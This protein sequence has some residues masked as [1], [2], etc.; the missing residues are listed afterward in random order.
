[1]TPKFSVS[2]SELQNYLKLAE[3]AV[4]AGD[5]RR[6]MQ[7]AHEASARG[8]EHPGLLTLAMQ[9]ELNAQR[10]EQ[11]LLL[12]ERA[13]KLAPRALEV[14]RALAS[15]YAA[16]GRDREAIAAYDE[17]LRQAPGNMDLRYNR[18]RLMEDMSKPELARR[19]YERVLDSVPNHGPALS[20]LAAIAGAAGR[21]AAARD[22]ATRALRINPRETAA[23]I[24][25]AQADFADKNY[26]S[27]M[28]IA[29]PLASPS[30]PISVNRSIAHGL[31]ADTLDAMGQHDEAYTAYTASNQAMRSH[32]KQFYEA[33]GT[34]TVLSRSRRIVRYFQNADIADW[35][36]EPRPQS[37][38]STHV[39]LLGFP[40]SGTTLLEQVLG[41]HPA[42]ET[43]EEC[44]T[45]IETERD[46]FLPA[47]GLDAFAAAKDSE[48]EPY[49]QSYWSIVRDNQI[50]L[51]HPAFVDKM[52]LNSFLLGA[53][54]RLF[55]DAKILLAIRDPRDVVLSCFRRRFGM[56]AKMYELLTLEGAAD[57]Y[58]AAMEMCEI[59]REKF[60]MPFLVTRY[61]DLVGNFESETRSLCEF[62]GV[63]FSAEMA[64]FAERAREKH[65]NTPSAAQVAQGLYTRGVD[66]WRAYRAQIAPVLPRLAPWIAKFGYAE[67]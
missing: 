4:R 64:N 8:F 40:R 31:I 27:V 1:M 14:L 16:L 55:P 32:F 34:E 3:A 10:P 29:K 62:L 28:A 65:V 36:K 7:V 44:D 53:I 12:A 56:S 46:F 49:R 45:L 57:F 2:S 43:L 42:I 13:R 26:E 51:D 39:F 9:F 23:S 50:G 61:E 47:G 15:T 11:A 38:V 19:D 21:F 24:V 59:A 30:N 67:E 54:A 60:P 37:P 66:Q 17:A 6:A 33:L 48:L 58:A 52:P 20:R 41:N 18:G 35:N 22:Y 5:M 25:L 63:D